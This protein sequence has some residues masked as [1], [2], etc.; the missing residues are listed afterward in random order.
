MIKIYANNGKFE[1][2]VNGSGITLI[3]EITGFFDSSNSQ[4]QKY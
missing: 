1:T 2:K 4:W 3:Y